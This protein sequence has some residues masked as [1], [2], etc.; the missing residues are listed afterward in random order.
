MS[1][2]ISILNI[3]NNRIYSI[4]DSLVWMISFNAQEIEGINIE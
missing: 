3:K 2:N 1:C 4:E